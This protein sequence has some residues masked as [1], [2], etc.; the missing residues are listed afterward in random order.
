MGG[1]GGGAGTPAAR[2]QTPADSIQDVSVLV[3]GLQ[4]RCCLSWLTTNSA[5]VN[6]PK[7]GEGGVAGCQPMSTAVHR[8]PNK[9]WRSNSVI[10]LRF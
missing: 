7:C 3:R 2:K 1:A 6:E 10:N 9:L 8:S 4:K 5:L